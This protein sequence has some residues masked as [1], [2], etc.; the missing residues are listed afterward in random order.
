MYLHLGQDTVVEKA[1]VI[2]IFDLDTATVAKA[3]RQYLSAKEKEKQVVTVSFELPR[4]FTVCAGPAGDNETVYLS[5][6][7]PGTLEKRAA[8]RAAFAA[9]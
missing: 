7:T 3:T 9:F 5:P 1:D 4:S 2:G 6:L 8:Q